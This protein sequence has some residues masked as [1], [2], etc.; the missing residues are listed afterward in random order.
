MTADRKKR[1]IEE[2]RGPVLVPAIAVLILL[3]GTLFLGWHVFI[4]E[5]REP[6]TPDV[7]QVA[8]LV[9]PV[10]PGAK[11]A[12]SL[13]QPPVT[14]DAVPEEVEQ[15]P[16]LEPMETESARTARLIR[17]FFLSLDS[18]EYVQ[19]RGLKGKTLEHSSELIS[20]LLVTTPQVVNERKSIEVVLANAAHFFRTLKKENLFFVRDVLTHESVALEGLAENLYRWSALVEKDPSLTQE[21]PFDLGF[22][23]LYEYAG[24]FLNTLGGQSYLLRRESRLRTLVRYYSVLIVD[25]ANDR[26]LNRH[27]LDIRPFIDG[28]IEDLRGNGNLKARSAY[29]DTMLALKVKYEAKYNGQLR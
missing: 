17:E 27:G 7:G 8:P 25:R 16:L 4:K 3:A 6:V 14:P 29:L 9:A 24:F 1:M 19:R 18:R 20:N 15:Q 11:T 22:P 23:A 5:K 12:L 28:A 26:S 21:L 10:S 2:K 13:D